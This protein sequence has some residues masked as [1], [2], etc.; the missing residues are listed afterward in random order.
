MSSSRAAQTTSLLH[1]DS[2][3]GGSY[4]KLNFKT[5]ES[6][7][8][9]KSCPFSKTSLSHLP[10]LPSSILPVPTILLPSSSRKTSLSRP[11]STVVRI[12]LS[13]ICDCT[14]KSN[15]P[16]SAFTST[17]SSTATTAKNSTSSL[18]PPSP[19]HPLHH[20]SDPTPPSGHPH[21]IT[22]LVHTPSTSGL[23]TSLLAALA[24]HSCAEYFASHAYTSYAPCATSIPKMFGSHAS[25]ETALAEPDRPGEPS[26]MYSSQKRLRLRVGRHAGV[27]RAQA[28]DGR[29]ERAEG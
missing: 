19:S 12:I 22:S 8:L 21:H 9:A 11:S 14:V 23:A 5:G 18:L 28:R 2:E 25:R 15:S 1:V 6:F 13:N 10:A 24:S 17:V 27:G 3:R 20:A 16:T 26:P 29:L 7:H 4:A